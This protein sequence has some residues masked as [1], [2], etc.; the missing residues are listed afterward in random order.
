M[1]VAQLEKP[2]PNI[3]GRHARYKFSYVI[4]TPFEIHLELEFPIDALLKLCLKIQETV[5]ESKNQSDF[6]SIL[7]FWHLSFHLLYVYITFVL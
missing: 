2:S 7:S 1:H 4:A 6:F 5:H 3:H